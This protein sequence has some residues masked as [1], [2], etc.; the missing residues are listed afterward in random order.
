V[1]AT[2]VQRGPQGLFAW[3]I[4][5]DD[6]VEQRPIEVGPSTKEVVVVA[7]GLRDGE[8]VVTGGQYKLKKGVAVSVTPPAIAAAGRSS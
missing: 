2:A 8:R 3:V 7:T 5:A 4:A 6:T 1:P